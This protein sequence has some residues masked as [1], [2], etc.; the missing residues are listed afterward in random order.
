MDENAVGFGQN[1]IDINDARV[2]YEA[3]WI[4]MKSSINVRVNGEMINTTY[5]RLLFNEITPDELD[6]INETVGKWVLKKALAESYERLWSEKTA[7][8]ANAIMIFGFESA[9]ISWLSISKEDMIMPEI[10]KEL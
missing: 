8:F 9:T 4:T 1:F 3:G 7:D 2:A 6:F 5:W 10:K